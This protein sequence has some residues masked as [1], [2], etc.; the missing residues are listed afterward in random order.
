[1]KKDVEKNIKKEVREDFLLFLK[2]YPRMKK[3]DFY[4]REQGA[5]T[6][7]DIGVK[8]S[9]IS[10]KEAEDIAINEMCKIE[11]VLEKNGKKRVIEYCTS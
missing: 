6:V 7:L 5:D 11:E 8:Y 2:A 1:M 3:F 4:Y 10:T 9:S